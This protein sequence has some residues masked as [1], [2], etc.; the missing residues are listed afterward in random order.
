MPDLPSA[1]SRIGPIA[2]WDVRSDAWDRISPGRVA[3][4]SWWIQKNLTGH[5]RDVCRVDFHELELGEHRFWLAVVHCYKRNGPDGKIACEPP[6]I[7]ALDELPPKHL[8]RTT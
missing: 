2:T 1:L 4:M 7:E 5:T 8:L 3:Q 6:V